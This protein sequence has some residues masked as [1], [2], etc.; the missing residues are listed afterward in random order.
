MTRL[1]FKEEF[2]LPIVDSVST[3]ISTLPIYSLEALLFKY[4]KRILLR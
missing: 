2:S 4:P 1:S 3:P